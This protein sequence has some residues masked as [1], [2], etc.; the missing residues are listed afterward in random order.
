MVSTLLTIIVSYGPYSIHPPWC[1]V[2]PSSLHILLHYCFIFF[3]ESYSNRIYFLCNGIPR[4]N[5][6]LNQLRFIRKRFTLAI[7]KVYINPFGLYVVAHYQ[8]QSIDQLI[9]TKIDLWKLSSIQMTNYIE[10]HCMNF[11]LNSNS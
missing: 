7:A 10:W 11:E 2:S 8:W 9:K 5:Q 1:I 3:S 6:I 4:W